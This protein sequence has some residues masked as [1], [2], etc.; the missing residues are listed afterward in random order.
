MQSHWPLLVVSFF[1]FVV[2][3]CSGISLLLIIFKGQEEELRDSVMDLAVETGAWFA[4]ELDFSILPLFSMAQFASE[5]DIFADLPE[6]I[7]S[8][9]EPGALPFLA[10]R[11]NATTVYRNVTGVCDQ[12]ELIDRF[13]D[14]ASAV[15]T[16]A[17][18]DGVLHNIQLAPQGMFLY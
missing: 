14:I 13:V 15:K 9:G 1:I 17:R 2:L 18:M 12:P 11:A 5:L 4:N 3:A 7:K 16:N 10:Q 8:P 6:K